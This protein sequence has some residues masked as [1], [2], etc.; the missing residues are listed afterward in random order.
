MTMMI[1]HSRPWI[2]ADDRAAVEAA[3]QD[4]MI[5]Q[6]RR[7]AA[8][9]EA[10]AEAL[11]AGGAVA[12]SSG[13]AALV[14]G[15]KALGVGTGAEVVLPTYVCRSVLEAVTTVGAAPV[16]C[17]V[18]AG[19]VMTP[20]DVAAVL[21][22]RTAAIVVVHTFGRVAD[23]PGFVALGVPI[24]E[25]ACQA[26]GAR[27][28]GRPVGALADLG[29]CSFHA[30]KCLT[31]GEGGML[32]G[33]TPALLARARA[34]RDEHPAR[35]PAPMSD[36]QAALG[37][38]QLA[39]Y[40]A[41]LDR[42]LAIARRYLEAL[43]TLPVGLPVRGADEALF[44][45]FPVRVAGD[46]DALIPRFEATGVQVRRGVD[47]LL[48]RPLGMDAGRF[49]GAERLFATTLSLPLYPALSDDEAAAV[50]AACRTILEVAP[51]A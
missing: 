15:L 3:L 32:V 51:C 26:F 48:H 28:A 43:A 7:V 20:D 13:T 38:S 25:D 49:A 42:R 35:V 11:G 45:R 31:T 46:V 5:A 8:F 44:F 14:L 2:T 22:R 19:W 21:S 41:F 30:T 24:I 37:L 4:G 47:A 29:V 39:R 10:V 34:L 6:G 1:P 17:D 50:V 9:E 16:L 12:T 36:L 23:V 40:G 27:L 33:R 18:G